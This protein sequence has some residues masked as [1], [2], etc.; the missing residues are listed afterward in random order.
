MNNSIFGESG[1]QITV[2][3][4][5][6]PVLAGLLIAIVKTYSTYKNL[7]NRRKLFEF[8]KKIETLTP[9]ELEFF[10]SIGEINLILYW[11]LYFLVAFRHQCRRIFRDQIRSTRCRSYQLVKFWAASAS[12]YQY[13]VLGLGLFC[14]GWTFLLRHPTGK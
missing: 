3:L 4:I 6:I 13:G 11:L 14:H 2:F 12:S 10:P 7:K 1:I 5:L 8:N 9:E